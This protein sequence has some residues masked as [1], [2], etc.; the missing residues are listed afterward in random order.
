MTRLVSNITLL[1]FNKTVVV[2]HITVVV[3]NKTGYD[4]IV[5]QITRYELSAFKLDWDD[6]DYRAN[7]YK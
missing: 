1:V 5:S 7:T 6:I 4:I 2:S 3:S